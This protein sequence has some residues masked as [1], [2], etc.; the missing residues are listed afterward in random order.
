VAE[1]FR[2]RSL[3][4]W[5]K[6]PERVQ[7]RY[8]AALENLNTSRV[9]HRPLREVVNDDGRI[10]MSTQ[11]RYTRSATRRD[12]AGRIVAKDADRLFRPM[13]IY[14]TGH[15]RVLRAVYGSRSASDIAGHQSALD[16]FLQTGDERHLLPY[17]G[18]RRAGVEFESDPDA[19]EQA[20]R[21]G[22]LDDLEP[23]VRGRV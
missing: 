23:Y 7:D 18:L 19:I 9:E 5:D 15:R 21:E 1:Q 22:T 20:A 3:R 11:M 17:R 8:L 13:E 2:F 16:R 10:S 12:Y 6:A 14:G 4:H